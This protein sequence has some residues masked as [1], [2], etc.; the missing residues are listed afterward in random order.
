MDNQA[1]KNFNLEERTTQFGKN[2][3]SLL[4]TLNETTINQV[5]IKQLA[6]SAT[7]IGANYREANGSDSKKDFIWKISICKK[8]A[9][10]TM[11]WLEMLSEVEPTKKD[12]LRT[13]WREAHELSLIFGKI[14]ISSKKKN[15]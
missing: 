8:E 11:H 3:L 10:E 4:K 12:A 2:I 5:I 7:S 9:K 6:R 15:V 14:I 13:L 1:R